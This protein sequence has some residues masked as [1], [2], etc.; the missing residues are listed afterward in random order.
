MA[1]RR[2]A[3]L[4]YDSVLRPGSKQ[5]HKTD[6]FFH[7]TSLTGLLYEQ[8]FAQVTSQT[9]TL[10]NRH[11]SAEET[12]FPCPFSH[13]TSNY[14]PSHNMQD[15]RNNVPVFYTKDVP[16]CKC[17]RMHAHAHKM[18][19]LLYTFTIKCLWRN[20]KVSGIYINE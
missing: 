1:R 19:Y 11:F 7:V 5:I 6:I 14:V 8:M 17:K 9:K 4:R 13:S 15:R 3:K 16:Y 18:Y 12:L 2:P 20:Q 10:L